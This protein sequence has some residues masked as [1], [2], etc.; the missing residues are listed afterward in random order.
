[1]SVPTQIVPTLTILEDEGEFTVGVGGRD[2]AAGLARAIVPLGR[3][4]GG[5]ETADYHPDGHQRCISSMR[6]HR[7]PRSQVQSA[8]SP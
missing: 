7:N 6:G 1:M 8:P 5:K 3:E 4:F 2:N